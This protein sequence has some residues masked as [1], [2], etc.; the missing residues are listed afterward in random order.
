[1]KNLYYSVIVILLGCFIT[2]MNGQTAKI[3]VA[4]KTQGEVLYKH[5]DEDKFNKDVE[6][7]TIF[8][9]GDVISTDKDGYAVLVF[10]DDKSQLTIHE[11]SNF[12]ITRQEENSHILKRVSMEY[13]KLKATIQKQKDDEFIISTPTSVAAV[14]GTIFWVISDPKEGDQFYGIEGLIEIRNILSNRVLTLQ[15]ME[16]S[17]STPDGGLEKEKIED[18]D[19]PGTTYQDQ[20]GAGEE[21]VLRL[22]YKNKEGKI[23]HL[24]IIYE[25]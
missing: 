21:K 3:A 5:A 25:E 23:K 6:T 9:N 13:G 10:I 20:N 7:G 2:Q 22:R 18:E 1:M 11:N 4:L 17:T 12:V 8:Q 16:K 15:K 24:E 14:K 19:V